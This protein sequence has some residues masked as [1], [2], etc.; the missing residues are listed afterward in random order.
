MCR[1]LG[2]FLGLGLFNGF[3]WYNRSFR[4][5][6]QHLYITVFRESFSGYPAVRPRPAL[7]SSSL[8]P[9]KANKIANPLGLLGQTSIS[10]LYRVTTPSSFSIKRD[11]CFCACQPRHAGTQNLSHPITAPNQQLTGTS[12]EAMVKR[13]TFICNGN[14]GQMTYS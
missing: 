4:R 8:P 3:Q 7:A 6:W 2:R 10:H 11:H 9:C 1:L 5:K 13:A 12:T 14:R